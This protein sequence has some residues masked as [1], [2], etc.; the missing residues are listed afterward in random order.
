MST[1]ER[2][3]GSHRRGASNSRL[4]VL[5]ASLLGIAVV[6]VVVTITLNKRGEPAHQNTTQ[7]ARSTLGERSPSPTQPTQLGPS[8]SQSSP[9]SSS[10]AATAPTPS[11]I[12]SS[13]PSLS[14]T[15]SGAAPTTSSTPLPALDVL[16]DSRI[17]GLAAHASATFRAAGWDVAST[18]NFR[19]ADVPETTIFYPDGDKAAANQL[20]T[21]FGIHRLEPASPDLSQTN[22]TVALARDWAQRG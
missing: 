13:E 21:Q 10:T 6:A 1:P 14:A 22:L 18:G 11:P 7:T 2:P 5:I 17:T 8:T 3:P 20:A 19:G 15:A 9:S 16:N 12:Q 4:A